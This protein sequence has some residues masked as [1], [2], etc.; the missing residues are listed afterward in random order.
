VFIQS[1]MTHPTCSE[2]KHALSISSVL[3]LVKPV[4]ASALIK[5][6]PM[7]IF[8]LCARRLHLTLGVS[9]FSP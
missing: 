1:L 7:C 2:Y 9:S 5:C 6:T 8:S 4:A 3:L